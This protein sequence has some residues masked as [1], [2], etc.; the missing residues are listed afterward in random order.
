ME[1]FANNIPNANIAPDYPTLR[2][3]PDPADDLP[4]TTILPEFFQISGYGLVCVAVSTL[5]GH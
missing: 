1:Y 2:M 4:E 3:G 5:R